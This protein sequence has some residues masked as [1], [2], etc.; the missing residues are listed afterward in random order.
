VSAT[1]G[2]H[3]G[4][5][6]T[7]VR[8]VVAAVALCLSAGGLAAGCSAGRST[9]GTSDAPCYVA[10]PTAVQAVES[11]GHLV[12]VRLFKVGSVTYKL[13]DRA[14]DQAGL[15]SGRVCLVAFSG[16]FTA[17]TVEHPEGRPSGKL[18]VVVLRYPSGSLVATV[19]FLHLPT[20]FGHTHL[21]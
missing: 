20:H 19:L 1:G 15:T 17:G 5:G 13:L 6:R 12:G 8:R 14:I 9:L 21:F 7:R 16:H 10:L 11:A 2:A 3:A 4:S 18:A